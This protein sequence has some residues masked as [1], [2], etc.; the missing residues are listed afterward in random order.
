[1]SHARDAVPAVRLQ[2]TSPS[3]L[4][5]WIAENLI[6]F[7]GRH[8]LFARSV[9][10][11][12]RHNLLGGIWFAAAIF[13]LWVE[14][15]RSGAPELRRRVLS[16]IVGSGLAILLTLPATALVSWPPPNWHPELRARFPL[17]LDRN[18]NPNSFPSQSTAAYTAIAAGV[19]SVRRRMGGLLLLTAALGVGFPRMWVGGHYL[20]DVLAG[21]ALGL[22]GC[23]VALRLAE[24]G[25]VF[26][27]ETWLDAGPRRKL[28][29]EGFV[30][31]CILQIAVG[32]REIVW[33]RESLPVL[34]RALLA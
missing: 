32:F 20:S 34:L 24:P 25:L 14:G 21:L 19:L 11:A 7:L 6:E 9:Q 2:M 33:L 17:Y 22:L 15:G 13:L 26:R 5:L 23:L 31:L 30:F 27:L 8:E 29:R 18:P 3:T 1:M 28:I 12:I 16:T 10:S 4:D